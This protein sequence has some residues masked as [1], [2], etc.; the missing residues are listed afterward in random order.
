MY[1]EQHGPI[2]CG[3]GAAFAALGLAGFNTCRT[4]RVSTEPWL[5]LN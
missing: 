2:A 1:A 5:W 3:R 4:Y